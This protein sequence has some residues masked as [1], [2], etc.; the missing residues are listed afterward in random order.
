MPTFL[1]LLEQG[2]RQLKYEAKKEI[3]DQAHTDT[4]NLAKGR[5][6]EWSDSLKQAYNRVIE[7]AQPELLND[8][9]M[10]AVEYGV[11]YHYSNLIGSAGTG[12]T[13][14]VKQLLIKLIASGVVRPFSEE[15]SKSHHLPIR[16]ATGFNFAVCAFTGKAVENIQK[17]LPYDFRYNCCTIH[18]LIDYGPEIKLLP[19][20]VADVKAGKAMNVGQ[21]IEKRVF[22]PRRNRSNRLDID[23]LL[24]E[25]V[26]M[27]G[28]VLFKQ[29]LSAL[30]SHT[31][32]VAVGD[33][34]QLP[35]TM[36]KSI[37]PL[38]L[39]QWP[40]TELTTIYRQKDGDLISNAN[41][42]RVQ[43][44]PEINDSFRVKQIDTDSF[45][46]SKQIMVG[47]KEAFN[48]GEFDPTR[49]IC[50]T[51]L[52]VESLGQEAL[53]IYTRYLV[54][55]EAEVVSV[56]TMRNSFKVA[57]G[58]RVLNESNDREFNIFNGMLG[59]V[60]GIRVNAKVR[61][62][63]LARGSVSQEIDLNSALEE[64]AEKHAQQKENRALKKELGLSDEYEEALLPEDDDGTG[65]RMASH[66][67]DVLFDRD[68]QEF[69]FEHGRPPS[70]VERAGLVKSLGSS[71]LIENLKLGWWITVYKAQ[72]SGFRN[73]FVVLHN[74]FA[75]QLC[76]ELFYTAVTRA[77]EMVTIYTTAY[78]FGKSL[79]NQRITGSTLAD[80]IAS[81]IEA[82]G[83]NPDRELNNMLEQ[84]ENE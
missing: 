36:D 63:T 51:P 55:A 66:T 8:E 5:N 3:L 17:T 46:A 38:L 30:P 58:D 12:K 45:L 81:Y 69:T 47:L 60:M 10:Q 28:S 48:S 43:K 20:N 67:I 13:F 49:D 33:L 39:A 72:G 37:Q 52:N 14:T 83:E 15:T 62:K 57:V 65:V 18:K 4:L 84:L 23:F 27:V 41:A 26:S 29:L 70:E 59:T 80:K 76:N 6:G 35:P 79:N 7:T 34:A 78:A 75:R 32:I 1:E 71:A 61:G 40:T 77:E 56:L 54:N 82:Y 25:E 42:I 24:I 11:K 31:R 64:L 21:E 19:A 68:V 50:L 16:A 44:R 22:V 9:Q 73:V 53:N 2:K 74:E